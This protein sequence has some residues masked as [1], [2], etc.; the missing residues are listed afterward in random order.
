MST[1]Y[2][3]PIVTEISLIF[4]LTLLE[5]LDLLGVA[6][7]LTAVFTAIF[8]YVST[9]RKSKIESANISLKLLQIGREDM[10]RKIFEKIRNAKKL[11]E[12]EIKDLLRYYEYVAEFLKD[13]VL[14][15]D[16]VFHIHGK[17]LKLMY[18]ND[19]IRK[20][21]DKATQNSNYSYVNLRD[22]FLRIDDDL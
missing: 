13:K 11:E 12:Q 22:L 21:F 19:E 2:V 14:S 6:G 18:E 15:Y 1:W 10:Y 16:H 7:L 20:V 9:T 4:G 5:Y 8:L 17:N 3:I